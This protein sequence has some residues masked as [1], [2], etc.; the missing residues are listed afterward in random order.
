MQQTRSTTAVGMTAQEMTEHAATAIEN[1]R[2]VDELHGSLSTTQLLYETSRRISTAMTVDEV[3]AAYLEQVATGGRYF[4]T[5]STFEIDAGG[6]PVAAICRMRWSPDAGLEHPDVTVPYAAFAGIDTALEAG[7]TVTVADITTDGRITEQFRSIQA[8]AG[9]PSLA[10]IPLIA[11]GRPLGLV[12]LSR[13]E[14]G[15]WEEA[16]LRPYQVT[17]AQ[18]AAALDSRQQHRLLVE[19]GQQLAVLEERRRL[20]RE[21]HDSVTQSLVSMSLLAQTVPQLWEIDRGE[22]HDAL[23]QIRDL[24]RGALA[25]MRA[26]LCEL[27]PSA[28]AG[29][30]LVAGLMQQAAAAERRIGATVT[31]AIDETVVVP[32]AVGHAFTRIAQ[33]ALANIARH[34]GARRV[35]LTL[36]GRNPVRLAIADDGRGFELDRIGD[37]CFGLISMRERAA[38]IGARLRIDSARGRGTT[39]AVEWPATV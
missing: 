31:R 11:R 19:R 35:S 37:R 6:R 17:A 15:G 18:L 13:R 28:G 25:E 5:V 3:I 38:G 39:V 20:A 23:T 12:S 4:S 32:E 16:D 2:L 10:L 24:T 33:E 9:R 29:E 7:E 21:L 36:T 14:V 8:A 1:A 27:R 26:L 22:A 30:S 34:A